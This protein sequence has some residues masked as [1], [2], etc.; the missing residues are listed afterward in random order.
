MAKFSYTSHLFYLTNW[1]L[2]FSVVSCFLSFYL[3]RNRQVSHTLMKCTCVCL[4]LALAMQLVIVAVYWPVLHRGMLEELAPLNDWLIV[5]VMVHIHWFPFFAVFLNMSLSKTVPIAA[6]YH[7]IIQFGCVYMVFNYI[8]TQFKGHPLYPFMPWT[9]YMT[10]VKGA[11]IYAVTIGC[12]LGM[13]YVV[14][15]VK[16]KPVEYKT[17]KSE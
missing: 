16:T 9:D 17:A 1:G 12:Y 10:V 8:G 14:G 2:E 6:H 15:K 5:Q 4:E 7:Y 11:G 3:G 13:C